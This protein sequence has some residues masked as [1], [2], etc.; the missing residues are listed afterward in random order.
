MHDLTIDEFP[1]AFPKR[2]FLYPLF[3]Q[4]TECEDVRLD[5]VFSSLKYFQFEINEVFHDYFVNKIL[6]ALH[7]QVC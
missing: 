4:H 2:F 7:F 3:V 5:Q 1:T 6:S